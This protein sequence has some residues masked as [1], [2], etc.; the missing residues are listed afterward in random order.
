MEQTEKRHGRK[1][2]YIRSFF[3]ALFDLAQ[4]DDRIDWTIVQVENRAAASHIN[5]IDNDQLL[6]WQVYFDKDY[7]W[8]KPNQ[9]LLVQAAQRAYTVGVTKL[10]LGATPDDADG[11]AAY[12]KKWGGQPHRYQT[13]VYHRKGLGWIK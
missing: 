12:K 13:L 5:L 1:P 4:K 7:S 3:T 10:C 11:V 8:L 9:Y 2:K 6:N